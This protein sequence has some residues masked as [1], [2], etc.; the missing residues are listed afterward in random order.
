MVSCISA[1]RLIAVITV[2]V[3]GPT[4]FVGV[5]WERRRPLEHV[6]QPL[7]QVR[8]AVRLVLVVGQAHIGVG[9]NLLIAAVR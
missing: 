4:V 5:P 2:A 9:A 7:F 6:R 1:G 8:L 3:N